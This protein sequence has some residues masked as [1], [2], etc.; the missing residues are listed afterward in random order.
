MLG[1]FPKHEAEHINRIKTDD[2]WENLRPATHQQNMLNIEK[3]KTNSSGIIGVSFWKRDRNW[4]AC[5]TVSY[6][7]IRLGYFDTKIEAVKA[8]Y[9]AEKKYGFAK[10]NR[11]SSAYE[12]LKKHGEL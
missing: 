2:R 7:T 8:R 1:H 12:Y 11:K 9:Y 4:T 6:K 3:R 10:W 5:I